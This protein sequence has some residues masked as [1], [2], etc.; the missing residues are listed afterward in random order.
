MTCNLDQTYD[1]IEAM[2]RAAGPQEICISLTNFTGRFGLTS[3]IAGTMP[4]PRDHGTAQEQHVLVSAFPKGWM[5]R[6]LQQEYVHIDP[7]IRRIQQD[8]SPFRWS[9]AAA[10]APSDQNSTVSRM[11]GEANEFSLKDGF[12]VPMLTLDGSIA[13]VSLGGERLDLPPTAAGMISMVSSFAIARAIELKSQQVR[14]RNAKLTP[15]EIECIKWAADGKTEWEISTILGISEHTADKHLSNAHRKL[16]AANR[17]QAVA[18][19]LR[20]GLIH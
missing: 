15:R 14:R 16:Q 7:V 5:E 8:L 4:S 3:M 10:L 6:Y 9:E 20:L 12:A 1:V 18:N 2:R 17:P 13:A 19:A 11:F